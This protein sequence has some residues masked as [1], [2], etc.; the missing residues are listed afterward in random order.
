MVRLVFCCLVYG[1][2]LTNN[3]YIYGDEDCDWDNKFY[4]IKK[5]YSKK[6]NNHFYVV[7]PKNILDE[8]TLKEQ[9][10]MARKYG[11]GYYSKY[12]DNDN[13][14]FSTYSDAKSFAD[15]V[16]ACIGERY[17]YEVESVETKKGITKDKIINNKET[18]HMELYLALKTIIETDGPDI[19]KETRIVNILDD[20][21]A[22]D[23]YPS[24]KYILRAIIN[25]GYG[26]K[27]LSYGKWDAQTLS[28]MHNFVAATGF[29]ID[30]VNIVFQSLA[31]AL[32]YINS[33]NLK[34]TQQPTS[35][36]TPH[37]SQVFDISKYTLGYEEICRRGDAFEKSYKAECEA[38]IDSVIEMKGNW[39]KLGA[40]FKP[41]CV[42]S[43]YL[44]TSYLEFHV[45]VDGKI[46]NILRKYDKDSIIINVVIYNQHGRVINKVYTYVDKEKFKN[47]YQIIT[48]GHF[49]ESDFNFIGNISKVIYYW[50]V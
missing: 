47:S 11:G 41:Y 9:S 6:T 46:K 1:L 48:I 26:N 42:Y 15:E 21:K 22:F 12:R 45:E 43:I 30:M 25:E 20:F 16:V 44:N 37:Q 49:T 27:L 39:N 32:G 4:S 28:L 29:Q 7:Q 14:L 18:N 24:T 38:Y 31:Y 19:I 36:L 34:I 23:S 35:T 3:M 10:E 8:K 2:R 40:D 13:Y 33:I 5:R 50:E 17:F